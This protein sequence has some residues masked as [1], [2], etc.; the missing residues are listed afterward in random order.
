MKTRDVDILIVP[1]L[2][3]SGSEHWQTRWENR[4]PSARRVQQR[5]WDAP[6]RKE[7]RD[8][9]VEAVGQAERPVVLIAHSL[10]CISV[11][12]AADHLPSGNVVGGFLVAP[13]DTEEA[14][15]PDSIRDFAPISREP[16]PFP[17]FLVASQSDPYCEYPRAEE[18]ARDWG[19][20]LLDAGQSGHIN[21]ESGH[22]P[23]PE[24]LMVFARF[25][26][27]L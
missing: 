4:L 14:R 23:W 12:D 3:G 11:T 17:C 2:G 20:F 6:D 16:M 22:G 19:A 10:G 13:P 8:A 1:G 9:I 26:S 7:W 25:M 5:D 27:N 15:I 21:S 18:L 24:G